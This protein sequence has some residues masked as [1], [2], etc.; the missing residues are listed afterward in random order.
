MRKAIFLAF[1]A[2]VTVVVAW[3][4]E[5]REIFALREDVEKD[6]GKGKTFY[7][8]LEILPNAKDQDIA[9]AYRRLSRKIHPDKNPSKDAD[10]RWARLGLVNKVLRS[11]RRERYDFFLKKGFP[12]WKGTD[13]YYKR[14]RPGLV[15]VAIF[16]YL[17]LSTAQLIL[18][19]LQAARERQH[20]SSIIDEA[21]S[22]AWPSGLPTG[23]P[24]RVVLPSGKAFNV[25]P[26]GEVF[27]VDE[28]EQK[29]YLLDIKEVRIPTWSDT[30]LVKLPKWVL[31][32]ARGTSANS[33]SEKSQ[34]ADTNGSKKKRVPKPAQKVGNLR[35]KK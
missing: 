31:S 29:T 16:L 1:L 4:S 8:W 30:L 28:D 19:R 10:E 23:K 11:D 18:L 7:D 3:S 25:H 13:Y 5:D 32:R 26:T 35:R 9:K 27:L 15:T 24:R 2:C 33:P 6:I 34:S 14:Y 22:A 12:T 21:K 17:F 20:M